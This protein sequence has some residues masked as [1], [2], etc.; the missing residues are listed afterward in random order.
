MRKMVFALI[1]VISLCVTGSALA[2]AGKG[3]I[4]ELYECGFPVEATEVKIDGQ[5]K[6]SVWQ[7]APWHK[8]THDMAPDNREGGPDDE[9]ASYEFACV[10]NSEFLYAAFKV[11]D[12]FRFDSHNVS[13]PDIMQLSLSILCT[14]Q[15]CLFAHAAL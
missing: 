9:D 15:L 6:E 14:G 5:I 11:S 13:F 7:F 12:D 4:R 2:R 10:A 3:V 8:V 1:L